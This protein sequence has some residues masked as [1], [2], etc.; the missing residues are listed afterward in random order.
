MAPGKSLTGMHFDIGDRYIHES[1][2]WTPG[3][4]FLINKPALYN[5]RNV[6]PNKPQK[7]YPQ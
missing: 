1:A 2:H 6:Y 3:K 4:G 7:G 5:Q